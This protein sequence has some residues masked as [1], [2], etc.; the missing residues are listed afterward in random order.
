MGQREDMLAL[1][2]AA[3]AARGDGDVEGLVS[4]FHPEGAFTLMGDKSARGACRA[5]RPCAK[6]SAN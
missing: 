5:T 1:I 2:R 3:Y 4:A 6:L